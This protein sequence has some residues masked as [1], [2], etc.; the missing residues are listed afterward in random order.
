MLLK[1]TVKVFVV[2][3]RLDGE[4]NDRSALR[5]FRGGERIAVAPVGLPEPGFLAAVGAGKHGNVIGNH[6]RRVEPYAELADDIHRVTSV[7]F[8]FKGQRA[9]LG[10]GTEVFVQLRLGHADA[11]VGN[12]DRPRLGIKRDADFEVIAGFAD[13]V[14]R[15]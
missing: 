11:V 8:L 2:G 9:A 12:G 13:L 3:L 14:V 6:K 4:G 15:Q 1:E 5:F 7:V 10:D